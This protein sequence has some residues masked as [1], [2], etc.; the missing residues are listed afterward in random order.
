MFAYVGKKLYLC[1]ANAK[2]HKNYDNNA[3]KR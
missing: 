2:R 1:V 3:N